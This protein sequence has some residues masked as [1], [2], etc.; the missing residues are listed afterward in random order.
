M[1]IIN[2]TVESLDLYVYIYSLHS[3]L[4]YLICWTES[5]GLIGKEK[6]EREKKKIKETE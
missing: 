4:F 3:I 1:L 5:V 6:S 2:D